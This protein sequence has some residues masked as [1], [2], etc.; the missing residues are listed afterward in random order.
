MKVGIVCG[1]GVILD[2]RLK[3]YLH[4]IIGYADKHQIHTLIL[5][6]GHTRKDSNETEA[7]VMCELIRQ[8]H[9]H[10]HLVPEEQSITTLHN[11]LYAKHIMSE[12]TSTVDAL[13]IFCDYARFMK[14]SC[15]SK[16]LFNDYA[17]NVVKF[18]RKEPLFWYLLQI[19]FTVIQCLGAIFPPVEK[20]ILKS[21]QRWMKR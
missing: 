15:L 11:L 5:C 14:V 4:S 12:Y 10:L 9:S 16:I 8:T 17:I 6:G 1:Y 2:E 19:P 18:E 3:T 21:R 13:Y 20:Q 7:Q